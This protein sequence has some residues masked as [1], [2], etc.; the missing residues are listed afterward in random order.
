MMLLPY[1]FFFFVSFWHAEVDKSGFLKE[2]ESVEYIYTYIF[3]LSIWINI[4]IYMLCDGE[5]NS[6]SGGTFSKGTNYI[7]KFSNTESNSVPKG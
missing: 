7:H 1:F 4:S 2:N 5:K 6:V 3:I